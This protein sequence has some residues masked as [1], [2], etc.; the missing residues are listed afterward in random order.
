MYASLRTITLSQGLHIFTDDPTS[1]VASA[2]C[3]DGDVQYT[4][5]L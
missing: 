1:A 2:S 5:L 4:E 3:T